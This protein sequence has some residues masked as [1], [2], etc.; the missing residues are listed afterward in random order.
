MKS[1][2]TQKQIVKVNK[3]AKV[4]LEEFNALLVQR[5]L[6][7]FMIADIT[8]TSKTFPNGSKPIPFCSIGEK[9]TVVCDEFG[10]WKISCIEG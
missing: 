5:G 3:E 1:L 2:L 4:L 8:I 9:P 7:G 10:N 6:D